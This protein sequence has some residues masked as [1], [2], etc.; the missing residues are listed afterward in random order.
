MSKSEA[1]GTSDR[2]V[3]IVREG[4]PRIWGD[5]R[6]FSRRRQWFS[7]QDTR[8]RGSIWE[9]RGPE[10]NWSE[11]GEREEETGDSTWPGTNPRS[12]AAVF[13]VANVAASLHCRRVVPHSVCLAHEF[14]PSIS[15]A[16]QH[17]DNENRQV[18]SDYSS[19]FPC[20]ARHVLPRAARPLPRG[21]RD[22]KKR[23][24]DLPESGCCRAGKEPPGG[25]LAHPSRPTCL[26]HRRNRRCSSRFA[27]VIPVLAWRL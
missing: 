4:T 26:F 10:T 7:G 17:D 18:D 25:P 12:G 16:S 6:G 20:T 24:R 1:S 27:V 11:S 13:P 22:W 3:S 14:R 2:R 8:W 21:S 5:M 9:G 15:P 19:S 23:W